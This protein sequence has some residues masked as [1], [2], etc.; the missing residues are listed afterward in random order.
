MVNRTLV[1]LNWA[2]VQEDYTPGT[3]SY[4]KTVA[5]GSLICP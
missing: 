1:S 5:T 2:M 4:R 3:L